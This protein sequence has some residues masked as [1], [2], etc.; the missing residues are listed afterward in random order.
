MADPV[1]D[2]EFHA[3]GYVTVPVLSPSEVTHLLEHVGKLR[4]DG[5]F[6]PAQG[7]PMHFSVS[8]TNV[9]YRREA[10]AL[11]GQVFEP[12]VRRLLVDFRFLHGIFVVKPPGSTG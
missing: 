1:A 2:S 9:E 8:D 10:Q 11:I 4:P 3:N 5:E 6:E 7:S 12:H